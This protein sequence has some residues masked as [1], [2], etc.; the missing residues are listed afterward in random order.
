MR[1]ITVIVIALLLTTAPALATETGCAVVLKTPDGFLNMREGP[2]AR[3][4]VTARLLSGDFL[5]FGTE[6]CSNLR[7]RR[8]CND[9]RFSWTYVDSIPKFDKGPDGTVKTATHGWVSTRYLQFFDCP[10]NINQ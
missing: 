4:D 6:Q 7:G 3:F 8:V 10:E 5:Y 2:G 9:D 1:A